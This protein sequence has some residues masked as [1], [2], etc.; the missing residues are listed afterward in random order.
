[1]GA[2]RSSPSSLQTGRI[3]SLDGLR[4]ISI[5]MVLIGH[6]AEP[7]PRS[8]VT[9]WILEV[10]GDGR[11]G[12]YVFFV[13]SGF[14]ITTLLLR[15][16]QKT[17]HIS[18]A[19]FYLRRAFRILPAYYAFL[20]AV[21]W[22]AARGRVE[23]DRADLLH[24]ISFTWLYNFRKSHWVLAH[25]W[26][27]SVEEQFYLVWPLLLIALP[28]RWAVGAGLTMILMSPVA[29]WALS[30]AVAGP[31]RRVLYVVSAARIDI[32]MLGSLPAIVWKSPRFQECLGA[33]LRARLHLIA[34]GAALL[35]CT[36]TT[37]AHFGRLMSAL[38][39][40][41]QAIGAAALVVWTVRSPY[42]VV[43]WFVGLL[44][45][46]ALGWISYSVY[47]WQQIFLNH[48]NPYP[49]A[50]KNLLNVAL[51]ISAGCLSYLLIERPF[52]HLRARLHRSHDK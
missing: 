31:E 52:L 14:L 6:A 17:Q 38:E 26:S 1:V 18:L 10:V 5:S 7:E 23:V 11:F 19:H 9:K 13:I 47:L 51:A 36:P 39:P 20:A 16:E 3:V 15:E 33:A 37:E 32:L 43:G 25:T 40:T 42:T 44:P 24:A 22:L 49:G 12:V 34:V 46:R 35:C 21:A 41:V 45:V 30:G 27:L 8:P 4:A 50:M 2:I 48:D 29:R 28:R